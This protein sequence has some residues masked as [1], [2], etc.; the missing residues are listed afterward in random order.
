MQI[1]VI[2]YL[3]RPAPL[4]LSFDQCDHQGDEMAAVH[5]VEAVGPGRTRSVEAN[6]VHALDEPPIRK[7]RIIQ[8]FELVPAR[9]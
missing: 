3:S 5:L 1:D 9:N 8:H 7:H 2:Q 4:G 6:R